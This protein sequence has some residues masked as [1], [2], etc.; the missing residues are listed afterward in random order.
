M[1]KYRCGICGYTYNPKRANQGITQP[2][3]LILKIYLKNGSVHHVV[4]LKDVLK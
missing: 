3:G 4:L 2:Q 1:D